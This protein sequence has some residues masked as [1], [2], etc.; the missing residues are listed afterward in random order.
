[1]PRMINFTD[2]DGLDDDMYPRQ[3]V[4]LDDEDIDDIDTMIDQM[5]D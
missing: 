4:L 1:M 2:L 3:V 5:Q